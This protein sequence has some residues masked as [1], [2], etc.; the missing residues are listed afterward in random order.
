MEKVTMLKDQC[1]ILSKTCLKFSAPK[2]NPHQ[3][4]KFG[5]NLK[6]LFI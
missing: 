1:R 6:I 2:K 5:S 4:D 3:A